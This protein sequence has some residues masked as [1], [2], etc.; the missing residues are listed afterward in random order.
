[1]QDILFCFTELEN[2]FLPKTNLIKGG[3][4]NNAI[5]VVEPGCRGS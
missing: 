2:A 4:L 3:D 1:M 5:V